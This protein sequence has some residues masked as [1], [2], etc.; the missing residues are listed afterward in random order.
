[1]DKIFDSLETKEQIVVAFLSSRKLDKDEIADEDEE[2]DEEDDDFD[3][4]PTALKTKLPTKRIV[5]MK[6]FII[7]LCKIR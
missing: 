4:S 2:E 3:F 1:M 7:L 6:K 5:E